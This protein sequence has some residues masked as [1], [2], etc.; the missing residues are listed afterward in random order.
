MDASVTDRGGR[1]ITGLAQQD[2]EVFDENAAQKILYFERESDPLDLLLVL[3]VS[4]SM[5]LS[6][7]ELARSA[8]AAMRPLG[9]QDRGAVM[10][11]ARNSL[12]TRRLT[13]DLASVERA[14]QSATDAQDL[15]S[16]TAI[17]AAIVSAASYFRDETVKARRAILIVTDNLSLNYR[18][19]DEEVIRELYAADATLNAILVGKQ[20][21]PPLPKPGTYVNPDFTPS[22]VF[23]LADATGG[24][25]LESRQAGES[26]ER[27]VERIRSRYRLQYEAPPGEAG[28]LRHI[29]VQLAPAARGRYPKATIRARTGY[30]AVQ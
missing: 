16:G 14:I 6:L 5:H 2:F 21:R 9:S 26:F 19:P 15:G 3:D 24:E 18:I 23:K 10:L 7:G 12:L 17:N 13:S 11:F 22:D 28:H 25:A 20:Y 8:R 30:Y 4:G 29:R 1:T 27:M